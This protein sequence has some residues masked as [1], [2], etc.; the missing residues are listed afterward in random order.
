MEERVIV[1][2]IKIENEIIVKHICSDKTPDRYIE[3]PPGNNVVVG[4]NINLYDTDF[5]HKTTECL[6]EEGIVLDNRGT[7]WNKDTKEILDIQEL[8]I[9]VDVSVWTKKRPPEDDQF[10]FWSQELDDWDHDDDQEKFFSFLVLRDEKLRELSATDYQ[11]IKSIELGV[12]LDEM[13]PGA[14]AARQS[15]RDEINTLLEKIKAADGG[16]G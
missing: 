14:S 6:I 4:E 7:W 12:P 16:N 1:E 8:D 3:I 2:A 10:S 9:D 11:V 15:L 13:Y 5:K